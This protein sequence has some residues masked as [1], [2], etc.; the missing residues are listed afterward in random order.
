MV[1]FFVH[2][3]VVASS[4]HQAS[5]VGE[6]SSERIYSLRAGVIMFLNVRSLSFIPRAAL[7]AAVFLISSV[8]VGPSCFAQSDSSHEQTTSVSVNEVSVDMVVRDKKGRFVS[9]LKPEDIAMTD[10][11]AA[12]KISDLRLISGDSGEHF[13]TMVFDRMDSAA[14]QTAREIA[15]KILNLIPQNGFSVCVMKAGSR[16]LLYQ[17]F[18]SDRLAL[19]KAIRQAVSEEP[20][21]ADGAVEAEKRL[22]IIARSANATATNQVPSSQRIAAQA[23]LSAMQE[24]QSVLAE[25]HTQPGLAGLMALARAEQRV[26]RRKVVMYFTPGLLE[27]STSKDRLREIVDS[28]NRAGVSIYVVATNVL[29]PQA[30]QSMM[31]MMA[32]GNARAVAAQTPAQPAFTIGPDGVR[33]AVPQGPP[34]LAPM[35]SSQKDRFEFADPDSIKSPL[36]VLTEGTSGAYLSSGQNIKK[37][38][39]RMIAEMT[40]YYVAAYAPPVADVNGQFRKIEVKP[41]RAGLKIRS[42]AGYFALPPESDST[43]RAFEA[44]LLKILDEP[45]LPS[46][47]DVHAKVLQLGEMLTGNENTIVVETPIASL[48]TEDDPN[49]NLYSLHTAMVVRIKD[50]AGSVIKHFGEDIPH[51]GALDTKNADQAGSIIMQ[52]HF[53]FNPGEYLL[54]AAVFDYQSGKAGAQRSTFKISQSPSGPALSDIAMIQRIDPVPEEADPTEPMRYGKGKVVP[55]ASERVVAGKNELSFFFVIHPDPNLAE[56]PRLDMQILESGETVAQVPLP[57]RQATASGALPYLASIRSAG[58]PSGDY[59][60]IGRLSQ[61]DNTVERSLSFQIVGAE[62][63]TKVST[64]PDETAPS[65]EEPSQA[66]GANGRGLTITALT[67]NGAPPLDSDRLEAL[68]TQARKRALQYGK[69]LP[70][71]MC[72]EVTNRSVD[73]PGN[74]N[75]KHRDSIAELLTYQDN[76]E[77]RTTL[78][79]NGVRS[80]VQRTELNSTWPI[81]VGEFGALLN[82]VFTPSS[83]TVFEWKETASLGDGSGTVEVLNYRVARENATI[84]LRYGSD[85]LGVGF[86]GLVYVDASTGGVRRVTLQADGLPSKFSYQSAAMAVDYSYV[87]ISG[88]D[89]LLPVRSTVTVQRGRKRIELNEISFRNYRRFGSRTKIRVVQ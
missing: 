4:C 46:D 74:G 57:L 14:S 49:S 71:F 55:S 9:D 31:A 78:Q 73:A 34:G 42:R 30:D 79:V 1:S 56:Q 33:Q 13:L 43:I 75:W 38:V 47:L 5:Y 40:T 15:A 7:L 11:G 52:R 68:I 12:V 50:S 27:D 16:L 28:S 77:S 22:M 86:H 84:V 54:E 87:A 53:S 3:L 39:Q 41:L 19:S 26:P 85:E 61:G 51:H 44:P 82:L 65:V 17:D 67:S 64:T 60:V 70:N 35:V 76:M 6:P 88:R 24:S 59:E 66:A 20:A 63:S 18:T 89:Y 69:V 37:P 58:L 2:P 36:M 72:V 62:K 29:S 23:L 8:L 25:L 80:S 83:K 10:G 48:K 21:S 81:S 32:M 45:Q